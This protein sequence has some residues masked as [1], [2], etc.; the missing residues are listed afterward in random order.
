[1]DTVGDHRISETSGLTKREYFACHI[2]SGMCALN[3]Q[4]HADMAGAAVARADAL[5]AAL[6]EAK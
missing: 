4:G 1:M 2:M 3:V 6:N 5:I